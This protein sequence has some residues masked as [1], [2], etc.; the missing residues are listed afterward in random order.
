MF[1]ALQSFLKDKSNVA[2]LIRSDNRTAIAYL[3]KMG[4]PIQSQLCLLALEIWEW[5]LL[6]QISPH[7]EYLAVK[8][9]VL[10]DLEPRHHNSSDWQL[11]PSVF[12]AIYH[13]LGPFTVDLFASRTNAQ[14]PDYCSWRPDPQGESC[15]CFFSITVTRPALPLPPLQHDWEGT[16][17]DLLRRSR[18]CL[19]DSSSL[20]S[21]SVVLPGT[22][23]VSGESSVASH[24]VGS[25]LESRPEASSFSPREPD[26]FNCMACLR[27]QGF[28][29]RVTELLLQSWRSN[30]HSAYNSAWCKWC[31]W[32]AGRHINPLSAS[33]GNVLQFLADQV[34]NTVPS[35]LC[36]LQSR[37]PIHK[38]IISMWVVTP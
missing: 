25:P 16:F 31:G 27:R 1:L 12:E 11:L 19:L 33:L 8:E 23:N 20:A 28:S 21:S 36:A 5:C 14:L 18:L 35:I 13:L 34:C 4:S 38:L 32:C 3:N 24:G 30:T 37:L 7:A 26:V 2:A 10:A 17:E 15:R 6:H 29:E 22:E 9:N